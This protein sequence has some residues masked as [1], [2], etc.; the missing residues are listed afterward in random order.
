MRLVVGEKMLCPSTSSRHRRSAVDD[1]RVASF[2]LLWTQ[3]ST[4]ANEDHKLP[5]RT[6]ENAENGAKSDGRQSDASLEQNLVGQPK[7]SAT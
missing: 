5:N 7:V 1:P 6:M 2:R 4:E 3:H